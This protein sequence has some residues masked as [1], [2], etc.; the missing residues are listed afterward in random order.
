MSKFV[1]RTANCCWMN[2]AAVRVDA[3]TGMGE[4]VAWFQK[5]QDAKAYVNWR[6]LR[7]KR[8]VK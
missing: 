4:D 3:K 5:L 2:Y 6:N 8:G 1:L 7:P